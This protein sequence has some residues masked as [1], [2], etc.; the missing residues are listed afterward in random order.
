MAGVVEVGS[1]MPEI[2]SSAMLCSGPGEV[3]VAGGRARFAGER[4]DGLELD[5]EF[6]SIEDVER[7][8]S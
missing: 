4:R 7:P 1:S 5:S 6:L 8:L 3:D 2:E